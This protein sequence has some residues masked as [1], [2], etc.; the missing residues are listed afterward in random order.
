MRVLVTGATGFLGSYLVD[1]LIRNGHQVAILL[2]PGAN[3][4]RVSVPLSDV[5]IIT[6]DL[7]N[8]YRL[9]EPIAA[10]CP[11]GIAHLAWQGVGNVDRNNV[12]QGHNVP[13]VLDLAAIS[14]EAGAKVFIGAGSQAEYGPYS[15][16]IRET[17]L[18]E[19]TTLY[20]RAKLAAG[21][22][23]SQ[24]CSD[25]GVRFGWLRIFSTYGP[26]DAD[27][28]L[29]PSLIRT[30]KKGKRMP[31]TRCEQRWGFLH[32]RDA[33]AAF[34]LALTTD[35]AA[36]VFNVGSSD[37]PLLRETVSTLRSLVNPDADLGFG[38]IPYRPDQVMVLQADIGR[39]RTLGW[40]PQVGL[41]DGLSETVSWYNEIQPD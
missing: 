38:D 31:L 24:V 11:D 29:I 37:A 30:L 2:R 27:Y 23:V 14:I 7:D 5:T 19:P 34:R 9:R 26:K 17:D 3:P 16:A 33:A 8:I 18:T 12:I 10:F 15:R 22:M 40:Q 13:N 20:G 6:G 4:W 25:R 32:A 21:N 1:D 35:G 39:L 28:W 36:G 41:H